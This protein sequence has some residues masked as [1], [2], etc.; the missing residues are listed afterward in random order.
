MIEGAKRYTAYCEATGKTGTEYVMQA[1]TFL[2]PER[3][4]LEVWDS[5]LSKSETLEQ[6]NRQ[7]AA[8]FV[9]DQN[10]D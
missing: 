7:H 5:P 10:D 1:A 8:D 6:R 4:Y 9:E 3:H 2:G